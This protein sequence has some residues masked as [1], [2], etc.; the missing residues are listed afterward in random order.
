MTTVIK[1]YLDF[2][3][4]NKSKLLDF[5]TKNRVRVRNHKPLRAS[6]QRFDSDFSDPFIKMKRELIVEK[7][8]HIISL[9]KQRYAFDGQQQ[10]QQKQRQSQIF[11]TIDVIIV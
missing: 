10:Q 1:L 7:N 4:N 11:L 8:D 6:E 9:S 5:D 3:N 2:V